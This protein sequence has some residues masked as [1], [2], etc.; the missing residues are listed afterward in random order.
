MKKTFF[1]FAML[2]S[3]AASAQ[4]LHIK[5]S[6]IDYSTKI[7]TCDLSWTGRDATHLSDIWVFVD[8]IEISGNTPAGVWQP[9]AVTGATVT[10]KT[11]GNAIASTVSGNTRGVWVKSTVFG[12]NFTGEIKLQL[13]GVPVKFNACAYAS[14]C[15]PN[16]IVSNGTYTLHGSSPFVVNGTTLPAGATQY[17]GTITALSDATGAPGAFCTPAGQA[18]GKYGCCSGLSVNTSNGLCAMPTFCDPSST[19][20]LGVVSFTQGSEITITGS[21]YT[22]IWSRPVTATGCQKGTYNGGFND[23]SAGSVKSDCRTN[24][25]YAGDF[26]SWCAVVK[27]ASQVCPFPWRIPTPDDFCRLHKAVTGAN[28][29][30]AANVAWIQAYQTKWAPEF[31]GECDNS[32]FY[33]VGLA[34]LYNVNGIVADSR[35]RFN[36]TKAD[37]LVNFGYA[38]NRATGRALRCVR[39]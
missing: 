19:L 16:A 36:I 11:I 29:V 14:D 2:T 28:C 38:G 5:I 4:T 34:V 39:D 22:Q 3:V 31:S 30:E 12:A 1:L 32:I 24:P 15:P 26:F 6:K 10:T 25:G 35:S 23:G 21:S 27:Y 17:A 7:V 8:Y 18:P 13:S 9:A 33:N 37:G 20:D